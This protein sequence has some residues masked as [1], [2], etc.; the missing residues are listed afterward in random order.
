M[1]WNLLQSLPYLIFA[2][3]T[4]FARVKLTKPREANKTV[5]TIPHTLIFHLLLHTAA[6]RTHLSVLIGNH[7]ARYI[8]SKD[9][10]TTSAPPP[11][12]AFLAHSFSS[13]GRCKLFCHWQATQTARSPKKLMTLQ[14]S[15]HDGSPVNDFWADNSE[16][17]HHCWPQ[18]PQIWRILMPQLHWLLLGTGDAAL[19][20]WTCGIL[21]LSHAHLGSVAEK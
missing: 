15:L 12:D 18:K 3:L 11:S 8:Y 10:T 1:S 6:W 17:F 20:Q 19:V 7:L 5:T 2:F 16:E 21:H 13:L 9:Q 4:A 14:A